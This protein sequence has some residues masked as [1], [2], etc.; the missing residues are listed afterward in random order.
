MCIF[1][2]AYWTIRIPKNKDCILPL[3]LEEEDIV[4]CNVY[5]SVCKSL[6][7]VC[8]GAPSSSTCQEVFTTINGTYYYDIGKFTTSDEFNPLSKLETVVKLM[9]LLII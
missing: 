5:I 7:T 2:P 4:G 9:K 3:G 1:R 6:D 8:P